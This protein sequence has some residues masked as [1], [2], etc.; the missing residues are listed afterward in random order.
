MFRAAARTCRPR[1]R[2]TT[3]TA[4]PAFRRSFFWGSSSSSSSSASSA[5][6]LGSAHVPAVAP[7]LLPLLWGVVVSQAAYDDDQDEDQL[8]S[9]PWEV[10]EFGD[11]GAGAVASRDIAMGELLIAERPLCIWPQGLNADE[12]KKLFDA[13]SPREQDVF[14]QL[15]PGTDSEGL[16]QRLDE[17]RARRATNGFSIPLPPVSGVTAG[18]RSV[19][20]VFPKIARLNHSC[21][22]NATQVMNFQTLRMEVYAVRLITKGEELNIEYLPGA[23]TRTSDERRNLLA[24]HFNFPRCLC[25]VC[26]ASPDLVA[27]SDARRREVRQV[28]ETIKAGRSDR[29]ATVAKMERIRVLLEEEGYKALPDFA[30]V[31]GV[32]RIDAAALS[33]L[34]PFAAGATAGSTVDARDAGLRQLALLQSLVARQTAALRDGFLPPSALD[35]GAVRDASS[36][37]L[38]LPPIQL[39]PPSSHHAPTFPTV[40]SLLS[41]AMPATPHQWSTNLDGL[42]HVDPGGAAYP[43]LGGVTADELLAAQASLDLWSATVFS[44]NSPAASPPATS[45]G[46][47]PPSLDWSTLYQGS[48]HHHD[49]PS[50]HGLSPLS[51]VSDAPLHGSPP[52]THPFLP[53]LNFA[54]FPSFPPPSRAGCFSGPASS[55]TNSLSFLPPPRAPSPPQHDAA[56]GPSPPARRSSRANAG[57]KGR[58]ARAAAAASEGSE[59]SGSAETSPRASGAFASGGGARGGRSGSSG[60]GYSYGVDGAGEQLPPT[61]TNAQ[62]VTK[63]R[64]LMTPDEVEED[65]RRRNT[66]ASARFRAKKRMRDAELKQS[67]ASLRERVASLEK[68]KES[69]S[70]ENRWLRDLV[71]EKADMHPRILDVLRHSVTE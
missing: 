31:T 70:N 65:K 21:S 9:P 36:G 57:A 30:Q 61:Y 11:K 26:S 49:P 42:N 60:G 34:P 32:D 48:S 4:P 39:P 16:V 20:C 5:A 51:P 68:E 58:A 62:G 7:D 46:P 44:T 14:M 35:V 23:V 55:A 43:A 37:S 71:S 19:G 18:G 40:S 33:K 52:A 10:R 15:S 69:L 67:S 45:H 3:R 50:S 22:P 63:A 38:S 47:P 6:D 2:P 66:E 56:T 28:S 64:E 53:S 12:A 17:V 25:A 59:E 27:Q 13:L 8:T 29:K 1:V 54:N 41:D 24:M